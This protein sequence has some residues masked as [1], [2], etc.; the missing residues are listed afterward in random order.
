[1]RHHN[2][3]RKLG[4]VRKQRKSLLNSLARSLILQEKIKTTLIKAKEVRPFV[5]KILHKS[6]TNNLS[7]MR[8]IKDSIGIIA[9]KKAINELGKKYK[10]RN[11]GYTRIVKMMP[12]KS[13]GS[14]MALIELV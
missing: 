2:H 14:K 5:E 3:N 11:G 4:R 13:D 7:T 1:M 10:D 8:I 12:R 9:T 6:K